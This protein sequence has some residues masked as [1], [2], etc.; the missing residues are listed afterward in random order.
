MRIKK[1]LMRV[2][3][4]CGLFCKSGVLAQTVRMEWTASGEEIYQRGFMQRL[5]RHPAGGVGLFNMALIENDAP[6]AGS[7]R[8]GINRDMVWG[9]NRARKVL[10][11]PDARAERAFL[12]VFFDDQGKHPLEF[13]INGNAGRIENWDSESCHLA[14]RW[15]EFPAEW[16]REG[17]NTIDL[18]CPA[19][20]TAKEGWSIYLARAEDYAAGGGDPTDVGRTSFKS[21]DGGKTWRESPF[22]TEGAC[23]AEYCVRLSLDRYVAGGWLATPVI[24]LWRCANDGPILPIRSPQ[25]IHL[26]LCADIPEGAR[27]EYFIRKGRRPC[28]LAQD[29]WS[30]YKLIGGGAEVDLTLDASRPD[31]RAIHNAAELVPDD[32]RIFG[33]WIQLKAVLSTDNPLHTP[34]VLSMSVVCDL[35]QKLPPRAEQRALYDNSL[36]VAELDNPEIGYSALDWQWEAWDRTEFAELRARENLDE[37]VAGSKTQFEIITRL[38]EYATTRAPIMLPD[39]NYPKWDAL[40]ILNRVDQHG[41][42]GFCHQFNNFMIGLCAAFGLQGRLV[43]GVNHEMAEIWSDDFG[44]WFYVDASYANH[45][46]LDPASGAPLSLLDLHNCLLD[47]FFEGRPVDWMNDL[48]GPTQFA[49]KLREQKGAGPV[50]R[51]S[52]TYHA[53]AGQS[54]K[55]MVHSGFLRMIPRNN[56]YEQP[57]PIPLAHGTSWWPWDG[58]VNWYDA[59]TPPQRQYSRFTDRPADLWPD[60]NFTRVHAVRHQYNRYL[61]LTFE[62]YTPNFSHFEVKENDGGWMRIEGDRRTWVLA[63]GRNTL[64]VRSVNRAGAAGRPAR[65]VVH[66]R[67]TPLPDLQ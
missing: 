31:A 65:W 24:D 15:V 28:P 55:G 57:L 51:S 32:E 38:L 25:Q 47:I 18:F 62:T 5:R 58:Y 12:V 34:R 4:L 54:Y 23:R 48:T 43:N 27:V 37:I 14:Y 63:P 41:G 29:G 45:L 35:D 60:L 46:L 66:R 50:L 11:L 39:V 49:A 8:Q 40:S 33:R 16:L 21:D 1:A 36:W 22:G 17:D 20:A 10:V 64:L 6:G 53:D 7:S 42:F 19:A 44:K 52:S 26:K 56:F 67:E 30:E 59:R 9:D 2:V 61:Y 13:M 3:L